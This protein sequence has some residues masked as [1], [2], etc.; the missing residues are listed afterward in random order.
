ML[1]RGMRRPSAGG[2]EDF[3]VLDIRDNIDSFGKVNEVYGY[4]DS[5]WQSR[6]EHG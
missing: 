5:L 6:E 4:F 2:S 1:G 3:F